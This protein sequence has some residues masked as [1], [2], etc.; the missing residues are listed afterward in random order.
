MQTP[1]LSLSQV[2]AGEGRVARM[3]LA[4]WRFAT[5]VIALLAL[6][7]TLIARLVH[8]RVTDGGQGAV[9]LR[10]RAR[11]GRLQG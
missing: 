11:Y 7:V 3:A 6:A 2:V 5:V 9:F 4:R 1:D 10:S 8:L